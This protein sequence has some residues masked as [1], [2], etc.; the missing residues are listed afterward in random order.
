MVS[1]KFNIKK[2]KLI[3]K[4][5]VVTMTPM[6]ISFIGGGSDLKDFYRVNNSGGAVISTTINKYVYIILNKYHNKNHCLLK[7]SKSELVKNINEIR[8]PLISA[9]LKKADLWGLDINS[10]ADIPAGTGL[11]SSSSFT[12]GLINALQYYKNKPIS[13]RTLANK[14]CEIEIDVLKLPVGKQDQFAATY[15]GLN[16]IKFKPKGNTSIEKITNE[17][18]VNDLKEDL[19][20]INTGIRNNNKII[21][22]EQQKNIRKGKEFFE[23]LRFMRNSVFDFKSALLKSDINICGEILHENWVKKMELAK[24]ITNKKINKIYEEALYCG[25]LGGKILGAGGR[26]YLML[27]CPKKKQKKILKRFNKLEF[28]NFEFDKFGSRRL[29]RV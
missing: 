18:A 24:G 5:F 29:I 9:C 23:H 11:G 15:G 1:S 20:I 4:N 6:R 28:L 8:H 22:R 21:L 25:A 14:A 19:I 26:G 2:D 17:K 3:M 7:Y 27:I 16:I 13:K 10:V 12:V